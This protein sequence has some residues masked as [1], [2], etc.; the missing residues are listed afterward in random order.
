MN[1]KIVC[2]YAKSLPVG[3]CF[4]EGSV[5]HLPP[6][7]TRQERSNIGLILQKVGRSGHRCYNY[8]LRTGQGLRGLNP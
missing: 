4:F 7:K 8:V 2:S 6:L 1:S 5:G 3:T